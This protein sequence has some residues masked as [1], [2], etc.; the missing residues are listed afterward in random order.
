LASSITGKVALLVV[1]FLALASI[2]AAFLGSVRNVWTM[3]SLSAAPLLPAR[4]LAARSSVTA[5]DSSSRDMA[6]SWAS[7]GGL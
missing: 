4:L 7:V 2:A 1:D 3:P 5:L 6:L